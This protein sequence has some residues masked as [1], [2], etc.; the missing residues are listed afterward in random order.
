MSALLL[1]V[2]SQSKILLFSVIKRY[3]L[4]LLHTKEYSGPE[5]K[6]Q[7]PL[8]TY[9]QLVLHKSSYP[10]YQGAFYMNAPKVGRQIHSSDNG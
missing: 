2:L 3:T 10:P 4:R 1:D 5:V 9:A 7:V 8:L 6:R